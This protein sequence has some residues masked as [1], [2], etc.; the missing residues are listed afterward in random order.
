MSVHPTPQHTSRLLFLYMSGLA[1]LGPPAIGVL[2]HT[3]L[4]M[5][6]VREYALA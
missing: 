2:D 6:Q 4:W 1:R 5:R 3:Y